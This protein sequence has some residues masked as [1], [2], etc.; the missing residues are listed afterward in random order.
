MNLKEYPTN[1]LEQVQL[2]VDRY[3]R[4]HKKQLNPEGIRC[5]WNASQ[6][7]ES[8]K[9]RASGPEYSLIKVEKIDPNGE[10]L[11]HVGGGVYQYHYCVGIHYA[12]CDYVA[13]PYYGKAVIEKDSYFEIVYPNTKNIKW[14]ATQ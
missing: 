3:I 6:L 13:D 7:I 4:K 8:L 2:V 11:M 14:G 10:H 1:F 9:K 5:K 12:D